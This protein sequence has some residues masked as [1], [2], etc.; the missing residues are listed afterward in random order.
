M[1]V[2]SAR[3]VKRNGKM[4]SSKDGLLE[5]VMSVGEILINQLFAGRYLSEGGNIGHEVINLFEDD[6]GFRYLY[7]TPSGKVRGHDVEAV[8]FVRNVQARRTV[9]VIAIGIGLSSVP[10]EDIEKIT[11]GGATMDQIF[12]S[13]TYRGGRD[14]F[15]GNV[16][17]RAEQVLVPAGDKR[18]LITIDTEYDL[19][20]W[21]GSASLTSTR[22]VVIPQGMRMYYS[23]SNDPVAYEQLRVLLEDASLWEQAAPGKLVA[24]SAESA[25]FPTFLELIGKEDD[26]LAFSNLLAHYFDY[27][28]ASFREFA[29]SENLLGI[30][31]MDSDFE[32]VREANHNIDLW[33]ESADHVIVIENKI[34]SGVNGLD[35]AGSS[36][37]DKYRS[38][39]EE[40]A[41]GA[42]KTAHFFIFAP[43]YSSTDFSQY[44]PEG[45]YKV[46]PYSAIH[47]FFTRNCSTYIA[48]RYFPEFLRGLERHAMTMSELNFKTMRSRFMRKIAEAQ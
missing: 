3:S 14:V 37:L 46:I 9:E 18:V 23:R 36:Q 33:I 32:I 43:D 30:S 8:I 34:R 24:D 48:D 25:M 35:G 29:E 17:Y 19:S 28:H 27:S 10:N 31:G 45:A 2:W 11:Y 13:N 4:L 7:V 22:S 20:S 42:G 15:S 39:A 12:R 16:T 21:K 38:K 47:G 40:Y 5:S 26:E 44:D 6:N 1:V 41:R